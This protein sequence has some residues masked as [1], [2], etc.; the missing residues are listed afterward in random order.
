MKDKK[1]YL[2]DGAYVNFDGYHVVLTAEN[3]ICATNTVYL[4]PW[5]LASFLEYIERL[6]KHL[7]ME[8]VDELRQEA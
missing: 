1:S 5:V 3:G 2:G 4:D 7:K 8:I 6:R